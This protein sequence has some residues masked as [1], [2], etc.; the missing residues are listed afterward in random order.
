[1]SYIAIG[2]C[3]F[4][5]IIFPCF[6]CD[7]HQFCSSCFYRWHKVSS[8]NFLCFIIQ[9]GVIATFRMYWNSEKKRILSYLNP[10]G[11]HRDEK[12]GTHLGVFLPNNPQFSI[13]IIIEKNSIHQAKGNSLIEVCPREMFYLSIFPELIDFNIQFQNV[14]NFLRHSRFAAGMFGGNSSPYN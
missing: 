6:R 9:W 7:Q 5:T 4:I 10:R 2:K 14:C 8:P 3:N 11:Q 12:F 1:M 13:T